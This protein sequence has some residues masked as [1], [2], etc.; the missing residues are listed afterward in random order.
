MIHFPKALKRD[1]LRPRPPEPFCYSKNLRYRSSYKKMY[2]NFLT[3]KIKWFVV[4]QMKKEIKRIEFKEYLVVKDGEF[5]NETF[6]KEGKLEDLHLKSSKKFLTKMLYPDNNPM[7]E[8][9]PLRSFT[10]SERDE[11]NKKPIYM[12]PG[13]TTRHP[14]LQHLLNRWLDTTIVLGIEEFNGI[15]NSKPLTKP[16]VISQGKYPLD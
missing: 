3:R 8:R 12:F 14:S 16:I 9:F 10:Q 1:S 2:K 11:I 6:C 7:N 13:H 15:S 5:Y 4:T